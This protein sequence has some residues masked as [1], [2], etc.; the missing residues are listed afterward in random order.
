M[1]T[2]TPSTKIKLPQ[3]VL[4][5][6]RVA[7]EHEGSERCDFR[8]FCLYVFVVIMK[9][10]KRQ[11]QSRH[12]EWPFDVQPERQQQYVSNTRYHTCSSAIISIQS[13]QLTFFNTCTPYLVYFYFLYFFCTSKSSVL[14]LYLV[15]TEYSASGVPY[16][17][18]CITIRYY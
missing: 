6:L 9:N 17:R 1:S 10:V 2:D 11:L 14:F 12:F 4:I 3:N 13:S 15:L 16:V 8:V 5:R 18:T 7:R